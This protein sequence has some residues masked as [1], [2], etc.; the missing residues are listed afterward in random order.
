MTRSLSVAER[1][2]VVRLYSKHESATVVT[3]KW[4]KSFNSAAPI[5][6][7]IYDIN[8]RF[9]D[10][11]T[12]G[13]MP[14]SG[15]PRSAQSLE[16]V[17]AI[18]DTFERSPKKSSRRASLELGIDRMAI[19]RILSTLGIGPYRP[20]LVHALNDDDFD[21]RVEFCEVWLEMIDAEFDFSL[22]DLVWWSDEST[23]KLN[24]H[25]NRHNAVMWAEDNPDY[26][27]EREFQSPG[28]CVWA[29]IS[30]NGII[31]PFFFDGTVTSPSYLSML[32]DYFWPSLAAFAEIEDFYFQQDGRHPIMQRKCVPG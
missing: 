30:S 4:S 29:A 27:M 8:R 32:Q 23:F 26:T 20:H 25:V 21:R 18:L 19:L 15:R 31:G 17:R 9:D 16:N 7:T 11:G 2:A 10:T 13:D 14:R 1:V 3:R 6:Q 22:Q 12:V 24:G 28:V 5:R